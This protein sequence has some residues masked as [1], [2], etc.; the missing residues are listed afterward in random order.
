M[1]SS[2]QQDRDRSKYH[3][4]T[5]RGVH[6]NASGEVAVMLVESVECRLTCVLEVLPS[7][8][9]AALTNAR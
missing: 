6:R 5:R 7:E 4:H 2:L 9:K 8:K 3:S 1:V